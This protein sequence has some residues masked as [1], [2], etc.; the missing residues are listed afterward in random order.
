MEKCFYKDGLDKKTYRYE[1]NVYF[2]EYSL[3]RGTQK[4]VEDLLIKEFGLS[5]DECDGVICNDYSRFS[6]YSLSWQ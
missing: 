2:F 3:A 4:N 6:Y 5:Q 1:Q